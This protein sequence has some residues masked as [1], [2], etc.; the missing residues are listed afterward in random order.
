MRNGQAYQQKTE[1]LSISEEKKF[2]KIDSW[3]HYC[4]SSFQISTILKIVFL[5]NAYFLVNIVKTLA[6]GLTPGPSILLFLNPW[7]KRW[8]INVIFKMV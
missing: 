2:G 3:T 6:E 1:K 8:L 4:C 5:L 7:I